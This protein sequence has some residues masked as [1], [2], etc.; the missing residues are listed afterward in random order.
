[1]GG[2]SRK[3][4]ESAQ[5]FEGLRDA[6][7]ADGAEHGHDDEGRRGGGDEAAAGR[8]LAARARVYGLR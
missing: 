8:D 4:H 1:M 5:L 2:L 6:H 3:G 7:V